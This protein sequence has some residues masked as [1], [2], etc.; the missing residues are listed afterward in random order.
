VPAQRQAPARGT[1]SSAAAGRLG[2]A[3]LSAE[4]TDAFLA[5]A[6]RAFVRV[7]ATRADGA[8]TVTGSGFL[9]GDRLV[10]TNRHWLDDPAAGRG[11]ADPARIR[12]GTQTGTSAVRR[13]ALPGSPHLDVAVLHL[14]EPVAPSPLRLGHGDLVRVGDRVWAPVPAGDGPPVLRDGVV[15]GF[16]S[17]PEQGLRLYRT[18]LRI[19]PADSGGPLLNAL[20]EVV[21]VLTVGR[22]SGP[23]TFALTVDGL[24]P[25]LGTGESAP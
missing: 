5:R 25:L 11:L 17:F 20:G 2:C 21:G 12:V 9:L 22:E 6:G 3:V 4:G 24:R 14:G 8:G 15:D 19:Q 7:T 13:I 10:V 18:G 23:V 1:R 16:E